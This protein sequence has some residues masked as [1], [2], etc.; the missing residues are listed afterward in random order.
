MT[1]IIHLRTDYRFLSEGSKNN[2]PAGCAGGFIRRLRPFLIGR[3]FGWFRRQVPILIDIGEH[4]GPILMA[5]A[6]LAFQSLFQLLLLLLSVP[7]LPFTFVP[8][9][10]HSSLLFCQNIAKNVHLIGSLTE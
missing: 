7:S 10:C 9:F 3:T 2:K 8:G 1:G 4:V 5:F 6:M